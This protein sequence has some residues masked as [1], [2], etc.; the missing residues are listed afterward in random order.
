MKRMTLALA[1]A[2]ALGVIV[3]PAATAQASLP[4]R[5]DFQP[6]GAPLAVGHVA[7]TGLGF[8][9]GR[10]FGWVVPGSATPVDLSPNTRI[11]STPSEVRLRTLIHLQGAS[12]LRASGSW[13]LALSDG[14]YRV[15]LGV[16][17][18]AAT[19]SVHRVTAEGVTVVDFTPTSTQRLA[20]GSAIVNVRDGRLTLT[21]TG[22]N[23]KA[24]FVEIDASQDRTA[25]TVVA[26]TPRAGST[27]VPLGENLTATFSEALDPGSVT[28]SSFMVRRKG[29]SLNISGA[30]RYDAVARA[31]H[32][33]PVYGFKASS[34]YTATLTTAVRDLA[35]N[36]LTAAYT[37]SFSSGSGGF[38][39]A[40]TYEQVA[41][42]PF[43][44]SEAQ[45]LA[46]GGLLY[47]LGGFD[48]TKSCCTP[49]NRAYA[50]NPATNS[51]RRLA[52]LPDKGV[53]HA[54]TA[55]DGTNIFYAGGYIANADWTGQI[56]G[57]RK[58]YRYNVA[59]NTYTRLPDLPV[60]RAAGQLQS[61]G[62]RLHFFG[63]TNRARTL[64]V[65]DH[66]VLDLAGGATT[67][68]TA[69]PLPNPRHHMGST[70][71]SGLIYAI[72]GQH[73]H[74][75]PSVAQADVHRYDPAT[76]RWTQVAS[77]PSARNHISNSTFV[78]QGRIVVMGGLVSHSTSSARVYAYDPVANAWSL[79]SPLPQ[80][81]SSGVG[82]AID[83]RLYYSG[84]NRRTTTWRGTPGTS[85]VTQ[86]TAVTEP[87]ANR[88]PWCDLGCAT[89]SV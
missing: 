38:P 9:A 23:T 62:G 37:W 25:P 83:G 61:L 43:G 66:Y 34:T 27:G 51:W 80:A 30:V 24:T 19:D 11:R 16:G 36:A 10:G 33:D 48:Y 49:T 15:T 2:L 1:V 7:D 20:T 59:A 82:A 12:T 69:A 79:M 57:T 60:E 8:D 76:D 3:A 77:L 4:L 46:V 29:A 64:D 81:S 78:L 73:G 17:D 32:F 72:G 21:A 87:V 67:W 56:F 86:Q 58:V 70:V 44:V 85:G 40:Y 52:D 88:L 31:A 22:S 45:G 53:T 42:Q 41:P 89:G 35:G 68:M 28:T 84:G 5:V 74:D 18:G 26:A 50:Y 65:G 63:G 71:L 39:T 47:S 13:E 55:T 75:G 6:S 14:E 54:G